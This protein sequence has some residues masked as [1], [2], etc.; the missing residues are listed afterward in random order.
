[1]FNKCNILIIDIIFMP[2]KLNGNIDS[3]M[4][5]PALLYPVYGAEN[6]ST[7]KTQEGI[8]NQMK[9]VRWMRGV[10]KKYNITN[11]DRNQMER[12]V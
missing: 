7:T 10:T 11:E 6:W 1:M 2:V 12:P 8:P 4:V 9:M 3:T 5:R